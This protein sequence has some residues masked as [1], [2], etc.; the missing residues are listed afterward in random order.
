MSPEVINGVLGQIYL[1]L[2]ISAPTRRKGFL[3]GYVPQ[4]PLCGLVARWQPEKKFRRFGRSGPFG[5]FGSGLT[6]FGQVG[7]F[8][9]FF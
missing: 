7:M 6:V 1:V 5:R 4:T 9:D 2:F 8:L 3:G